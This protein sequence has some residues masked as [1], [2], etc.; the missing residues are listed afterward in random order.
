[1]SD[2]HR[3]RVARESIWTRW[4]PWH[5]SVA[6]FA[7]LG[8]FGYATG[9]LHV[10]TDQM[11]GGPGISELGYWAFP[12]GFGHILLV[13]AMLSVLQRGAGTTYCESGV[14]GLST[15]SAG[16]VCAASL[17]LVAFVGMSLGTWAWMWFADASARTGSGSLGSQ[18]DDL[19]IGALWA[20]GGWVAAIVFVPLRRQLQRSFRRTKTGR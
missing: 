8:L 2:A 17:L 10:S 3:G 19:A 13:L 16:L 6:S 14:P 12:L 20:I 1:M 9:P 4:R 7:M 18:M 15:W 11:P 5:V